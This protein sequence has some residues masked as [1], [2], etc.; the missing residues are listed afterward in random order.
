MRIEIAEE[1]ITVT[2]QDATVFDAG[3]QRASARSMS[4]F[5]PRM[6]SEALGG[7]V[8]GMITTSTSIITTLSSSTRPAGVV[9]APAAGDLV[10]AVNPRAPQ[11]VNVAPSARCVG[12]RI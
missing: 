5:G 4:R 10:F 11:H 12:S 2:I 1:P 7:T 3:L 8:R 9:H 6:S